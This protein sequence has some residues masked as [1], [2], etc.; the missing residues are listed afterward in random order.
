M[1]FIFK[2]YLN[3]FYFYTIRF[4]KK[5]YHHV[6][7]YLIRKGL[8]YNNEYNNNNNSDDN[9][10]LIYYD[11]KTKEYIFKEHDNFIYSGLEIDISKYLLKLD[12]N[13]KLKKNSKL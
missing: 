11:D 3:P 9:D 6:Y 10:F 2:Q 13:L 7:K 5:Y 4:H 1:I 8:K 12:F